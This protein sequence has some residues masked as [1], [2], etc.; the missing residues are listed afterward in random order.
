M[1]I[2][3]QGF[4]FNSTFIVSCICIFGFSYGPLLYLYTKTLIYQSFDFK[5]K[6]LLHFIPVV[7]ILIISGF[8]YSTCSVGGFLMYI[9]LVLYIVLAILE[10]INY[11]KIIRETQSTLNQTDLVWLQWTLI[12]FSIALLLDVVNEFLLSMYLV[13]GISSIHLTIVVL[14]NWMFYKG[15]KQ[16]QIFLGITPMDVEVLRDK[17]N[18]PARLDPN[19]NEK[20]ELEKIESFMKANDYFTNPQ[21]NLKDL[22]DHLN[23]A[24]RHLSYLI[25]TF[26]RKNFMSFINDFRIEKAKTRLSKPEDPKETVL[27]VM[28]DVGFN[29]KSSFNTLF[30]QNTGLTPSEYK[31]KYAQK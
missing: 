6:H 1:V 26:H 21:L 22:A 24:P 25:N 10:I 2:V 4:G 18:K 11:R 31:N 27:E 19:I 3:G 23:I 8:G 13:G 29:S 16:P 28:Y 12:L 30:K 20:E 17:K 15:L 14:V 9:S 5:A 7:L